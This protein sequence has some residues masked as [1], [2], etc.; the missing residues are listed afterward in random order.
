MCVLSGFLDTTG[1]ETARI[2]Y[3]HPGVPNYRVPI[4]EAVGPKV[5]SSVHPP[6]LIP[7]AFDISDIDS[8][9]NT[10]QLKF[11]LHCLTVAVDPE[12]RIRPGVRP[13]Q[14]FWV[15]IA[16]DI[17]TTDPEPSGCHI[18]RLALGL[19]ISS[20]AYH[21]VHI[22]YRYANQLDGTAIQDAGLIAIPTRNVLMSA[23]VEEDPTTALGIET[24][25]YRRLR[26]TIPSDAHKAVQLTFSPYRFPPSTHAEL[27]FN[28]DDCA[29][30]MGYCR[31]WMATMQSK[32][33]SFSGRA[34]MGEDIV[35]GDRVGERDVTQ[36]ERIG[37]VDGE[38]FAVPV[39]VKTSFI[40]PKL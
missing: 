16:N 30:E 4:V 10:K 3:L 1:Y 7:D 34:S 20:D 36:S 6:N 19:R 12:S 23:F 33:A 27:I 18:Q 38:D 25:L 39:T 17:T 9:P 31:M 32:D 40:E 2:R 21:S 29:Q 24:A 35:R 15:G 13:F 22:A 8:T 14:D 37:F 26:Q 11:F 28:I 5:F